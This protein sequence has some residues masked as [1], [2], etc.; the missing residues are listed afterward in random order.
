MLFKIYMHMM[1]DV[2]I[3]IIMYI[4]AFFV[5]TIVFL[6]FWLYAYIFLHFKLYRNDRVKM[7]DMGRVL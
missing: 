7:N 6:F 5:K 1:Q 4:N 2:K 3:I